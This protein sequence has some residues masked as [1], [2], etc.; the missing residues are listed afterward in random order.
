MNTHDIQ[1]YYPVVKVLKL[2]L[3]QLYRHTFQIPS[4]LCV[5]SNC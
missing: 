4:L 5:P 1:V 2:V 3:N